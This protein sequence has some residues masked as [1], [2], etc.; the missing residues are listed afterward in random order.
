MIKQASEKKPRNRRKNEDSLSAS[1]ETV[2]RIKSSVA[3][4]IH[5]GTPFKC[6]TKTQKE[7]INLIHEKEVVIADGPAGVGKSYVAIATALELIKSTNT[8]YNKI[9]ITKPAVEAEEEHGFLPGNMREKMD[10]F[11]ASVL[12]IFDKLIGKSN[13][14][15]LEANGALEVLALAYLR[16][17]SIDNTIFILDEAQNTSP[18]QMKTFLT[19]IGENSKF[20]ISGD[21]DQSDKYK[22]I[23][24]SGLYDIT[25]RHKNIPEFG[26]IR[27]TNDEIVRNKLISKILNNYDKTSEEPKPRTMIIEKK[28]V[29]IPWY[30]K[31]FSFFK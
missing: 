5:F 25:H 19:R 6:K 28:V 18:N 20:I 16:G 14:I 22:Y 2:S 8:P 3:D 11:V 17:V 7:F 1:S 21:L 10:P 4:L 30:Q 26:F 12:N 9:I 24:Q 13:R 15:A 29:K 27:F 23:N 31:I